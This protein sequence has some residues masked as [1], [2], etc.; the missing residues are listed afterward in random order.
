MRPRVQR[1]AAC[2]GR[3][4]RVGLRRR[5]LARRGASRVSESV[6]DVLLWVVPMLFGALF[7]FLR[8]NQDGTD[9]DVRDLKAADK[10][11]AQTDTSQGKEIS[12]LQ[13]EVRSLQQSERRRD[14]DDR[15]LRHEFKQLQGFA[16]RRGFVVRPGPAMPADEWETP[17]PD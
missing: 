4:A 10:A 14:I 16:Q 1:C 7:Y 11:L 15:L 8:R 13:A 12:T 3:S 9:R 17:D 5:R 2:G 6:K